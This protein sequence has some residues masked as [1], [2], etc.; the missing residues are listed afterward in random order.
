MVD[1]VRWFAPNRFCA[2]PV[3]ALR[4][5]GLAI[6]LEGN[7]PARLA[8]A[9]DA[10]TAVQ[11][12]EYARRHRCPLVLQLADL[13]PW[14]L[15]DGRPDLVFE[16]MGRVRRIPRPWG[17]FPER[18]G[19]YSRIRFVARRALEVWAPSTLSAESIEARFGVAVRRV[20]YCYDSE[21]FVPPP[22]AGPAPGNGLLAVS[23]L[24]PH[25]QLDLVLRIAARLRPIPPVRII[26]EGPLHGELLRLAAELGVPLRVADGWTPDDDVVAAYR[27]AAVVVCPS[28]FEGIGLS[29]I[30]GM[31]MGRPVV[32]SD[33]PTHREFTGG[34]VPLVAPDDL[35]GWVR[36]VGEALRRPPFPPDPRPGVLEALTIEAC[37][38][39]YQGELTR[40][41]RGGR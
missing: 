33:I 28:R 4:R 29:P 23:R 7:R 37:A 14:R 3:P 2:L 40:V 12:H 21:R 36:A 35:D 16:A 41:L 8:L 15:G 17:R 32:A 26:G 39:R 6:A 38:A 31:A 9:M 34:A 24:V 10:Q 27:S 25:K 22:D 1:D 5:G 18:P 11:G 19:Y 20:P 13:P 30:E